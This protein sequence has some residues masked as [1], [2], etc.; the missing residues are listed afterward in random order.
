[1]GRIRFIAAHAKDRR[2][3]STGEIETVPV[4]VT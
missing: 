4:L 2:L 1:M 3:S